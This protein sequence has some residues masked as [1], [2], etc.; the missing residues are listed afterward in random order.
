MELTNEKDNLD[1]RFIHSKCLIDGGRG[2]MRK[3]KIPVQEL[4]P[5]TGGDVWVGFYSR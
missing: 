5:K 1:A 3:T 4:W 2:L